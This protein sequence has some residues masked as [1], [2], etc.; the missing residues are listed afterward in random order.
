MVLADKGKFG[1]TAEAGRYRR[2]HSLLPI[3]AAGLDWHQ[4]CCTFSRSEWRTAA[5]YS[6]APFRGVSAKSPVPQWPDCGGQKIRP[7]AGRHQSHFYGALLLLRLPAARE[8]CRVQ[9]SRH[10]AA[11]K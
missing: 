7:L 2:V 1:S 9:P 6:L 10:D 11:E 5:Q 8:H 3:P 4:E